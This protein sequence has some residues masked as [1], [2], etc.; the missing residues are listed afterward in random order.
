MRGG[1]RVLSSFGRLARVLL[2]F[3]LLSAALAHADGGTDSRAA[4]RSGIRRILVIPVELS[5]HAPPVVDHRQILQALF[6]ATGSVAA[7]YRAMSYGAMSFAGSDRDIADPVRLSQ[8]DDFCNTGLGRLAADA[9]RE[10]ERRN[11]HRDRYQHVVFILP[12]DAP[13]WWTGLG[14]IGGYHVWVKATTVKALQHEL[15]HNLGMNHAPAWM[16]RGGD[17]SDFMGKG[18]SGLNAP[19]VVQMG[20]LG[21]YPGKVVRISQATDLTLETLEADPRRGSLPKVVIV[22]PAPGANNYY[23]SLR[24]SDPALPPQFTQ[25]VSIH[26]ADDARISGGL[27]YFVTALTDGGRYSDGPMVVTQIAHSANR[28]VRIHIDFSGRGPAMSE[29][30]PPAPAGTLQSAASGKCLDLPGGRNDDGTPAIQYDCH[31]GPNQQWTLSQAGRGSTLVSRMSGKCMG[32]DQESTAAGGPILEMPCDGSAAQSW[33]PGQAGGGIVL[34]NVASGLCLDV[35]GASR[36]DG[37]RLIV[38]D[39]NGGTNQ[40]WRYASPATP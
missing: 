25:G 4:G 20:W 15:G 38:W 2:C 28:S 9:M 21:P 3:E 22:Q 35:P 12:G 7:R 39:C 10:V 18:A 40:T 5:G 14:D 13:C 6:G 32:S 11:T 33:T 23:L 37:T 26:I 34:R 24:A 36:A 8:P 1:R 29:G 27:T 31:G 16:G 19:H 30:P 17:P